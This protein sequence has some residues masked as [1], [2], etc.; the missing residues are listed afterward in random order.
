M[1]SVFWVQRAKCRCP[2]Q[3]ALLLVTKHWL[4]QARLLYG[5]I[6]AAPVDQLLVASLIASSAP[7]SPKAGQK[8]KTNKQHTQGK[9]K[10]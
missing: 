7:L 9:S 4:L 5:V 6:S 10:P 3:T 1:V 2:L 8:G